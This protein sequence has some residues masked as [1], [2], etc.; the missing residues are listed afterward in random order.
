MG[1]FDCGFASAQNDTGRGR[2]LRAGRFF[3][4]GP[5]NDTGRGRR[6]RAGRFFGLGPQNDTENGS[7]MTQLQVPEVD[8]TGQ[9]E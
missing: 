1:F 2:R 4:L 8:F 6:L 5:Q 7:G 9:G 3:G